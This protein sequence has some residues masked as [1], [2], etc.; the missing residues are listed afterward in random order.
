MST[1]L[2]VDTARGASIECYMID[3]NAFSGFI[4]VGKLTL[5]DYF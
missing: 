5:V 1:R 2:N 3:K 4:Y